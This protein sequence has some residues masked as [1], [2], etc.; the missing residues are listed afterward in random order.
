MIRVLR[1]VLSKKNGSVR[2]EEQAAASRHQQKMSVQEVIGS[3]KVAPAEQAL[4]AAGV[5]GSEVPKI[6]SSQV[7]LSKQFATHI[8]TYE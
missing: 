7:D 8:K 6:Q 2:W 5:V 4:K 1:V 3:K